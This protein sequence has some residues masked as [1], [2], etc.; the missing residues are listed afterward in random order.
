MHDPQRYVNKLCFLLSMIWYNENKVMLWWQIL[1]RCVCNKTVANLHVFENGSHGEATVWVTWVDKIPMEIKHEWSCYKLVFV[2]SWYKA[3][4]MFHLQLC[5]AT[6][7][8]KP[9]SLGVTWSLNIIHHVV[10]AIIHFMVGTLQQVQ[11]SWHHHI[12]WLYEA[13]KYASETFTLTPLIVN[14]AAQLT[15]I[16]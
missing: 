11:P 6:L 9:C 8:Q 15:V 1:N 3:W 5:G 4:F 13:I 16:N 12:F 14:K 10:V 7:E 2:M